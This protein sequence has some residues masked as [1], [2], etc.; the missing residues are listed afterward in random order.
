MKWSMA[1]DSVEWFDASD[2]L[3]QYK[4][5]QCVEIAAGDVRRRLFSLIDQTPWLDW[6]LLT[7]RPENIAKMM[8]A[9]ACHC[10]EFW[11]GHH[12]ECPTRSGRRNV[13]IGASVEN[14]EAADKRIPHLL[15]VPA[16]VRFLSCEPL[17]G[18]VE[19]P[20][21]C[22][23]C[24]Y[25]KRDEATHGDHHLCVGGKIPGIDWVI[26]GGESGPGARPMYPDWARSIR[27]QCEAA[28]V[29]FFFKQ[30]GEFIAHSQAM[31]MEEFP[32]AETDWAYNLGDDDDAAR[33]GKKAAGRLLD[34]RE[35]SEFP[36]IGGVA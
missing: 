14:Q 32:V 17:L 24:G 35:W 3:H 11:E 15:K 20:F 12:P 10:R 22:E 5:E 23:Q 25:T 8:P 34:G 31:Q 6:L 33:V 36:G 7:K 16:A 1:I 28:G 21:R 26:V 13:W 18:P 19:L 30:H 29:P 9:Y 4:P 27:D 2:V